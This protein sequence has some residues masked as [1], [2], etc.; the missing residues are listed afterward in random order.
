MMC[1]IAKLTNFAM[2]LFTMICCGIYGSCTETG[3]RLTH[4]VVRL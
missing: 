3:M 4:S 2:T 1:N